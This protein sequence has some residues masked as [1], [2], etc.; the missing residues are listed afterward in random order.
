MKRGISI[1]M[2][3]YNEGAIIEK[4][5]AACKEKILDRFSKGE[6]IVVDDCST[7]N[8]SKILNRLKNSLPQLT[9][10]RNSENMGHGPSLMKGL[11]AARFEYI[12]CI[13]SDY[14]HEPAEFWKLFSIIQESDMVT[15]IRQKRN[16]PLHRKVLS[17]A[18]S[19]FTRY[20]FSCPL[21]DLNIPFKLFRTDSLEGILPFVSPR[22]SIPSILI[23]LTAH[24]LGMHIQQ[25]VVTH[26]PRT[27]GR[28][29]L[30]GPRLVLFCLKALGELLKFRLETWSSIKAHGPVNG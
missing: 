5:V 4:T 18:V 9:I 21:R 12:F 17:K 8:T 20:V 3:A 19:L 6:I 29:S 28:C 13:D 2:P 26:L 7:D 30:P 11:K 22:S 1:V 23:T 10:H 14:Q 24:G 16:D 25:V 15:G 27:S